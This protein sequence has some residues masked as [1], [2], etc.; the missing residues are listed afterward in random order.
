MLLQS[1]DEYIYLDEL[2]SNELKTVD[3]VLVTNDGVFKFKKDVKFPSFYLLKK[4]NNNFLTML[5]K[6]GEKN[7]LKAHNDSLNYPISLR[8]QLVPNLMAEYNKS[9][10]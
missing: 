9:S 6:P 2:K 7:T 8:D 10:G 5:V 3:S 1:A 4:N